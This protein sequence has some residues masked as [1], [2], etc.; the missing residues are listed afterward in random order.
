M[1][2]QPVNHTPIVRQQDSGNFNMTSGPGLPADQ[3]NSSVVSI[4]QQRA[5]A[6]AQGQLVLA[7]RFPRNF[8]QA[9]EEIMTSCA[10]MEFAEEAFYALPRG[11][12]TVRG[13]SIRL[14]E[15]IARCYGN[16]Q[17]GHRELARNE[18]ESVVEVYAWDVEKNNRSTRQITIPHIMDTRSGG[19][20]LTGQKEITDYIANVASKQMRSRILALLPKPLVAAAV[21]RCEQTLAGT[22]EQT[23]QQRLEKMQGMFIKYGVTVKMLESYLN[24]PL[25]ETTTDEITDLIAVYTAIKDGGNAKDFFTVS[26]DPVDDE[27]SKNVKDIIA[28]NNA[29]AAG[30]GTGNKPNVNTQ[31]TGQRL[32]KPEPQPQDNAQAGNDA[33]AAAQETKTATK[34]DKKNAS[35]GTGKKTAANAKTEAAAA[36]QTED[37]SGV[38]T[39]GAAVDVQGAG[40]NTPLPDHQPEDPLPPQE[41]DTPNVD[42][43]PPPMDIPPPES[44]DDYF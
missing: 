19:K 41:E 1:S 39:A 26:S 44:E 11:G 22:G 23:I 25:S 20:K 31:P 36:P 6:E 5:I 24:H 17:Y 8:A 12:Q 14:A 27:S 32:V 3:M 18:G 9:M 2:N 30:A 10:Y 13:P 16:F 38:E 43:T 29:A 4:E 7:K 34:S 37:K 42:L 35:A 15:E 21:R 40:A 33:Q 28:K